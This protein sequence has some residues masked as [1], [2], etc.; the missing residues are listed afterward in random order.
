MAAVRLGRGAD[1]LHAHDGHAVN[2]VAAAAWFLELPFV[3]TR[4][5]DHPRQR[6]GLW[7]RA[8]RIIAVSDSVRRSL[9]HSGIKSGQV[10][11]IH[12][13]IDPGPLSSAP[14]SAVRRQLGLPVGPLAVTVA[15]LDRS[16]GHDAIIRTNP[17]LHWAFAGQGPARADLEALARNLGVTSI[18]HFV[19]Q[20]AS[21][22]SLI[23]TADLMVHA[24]TRE[25][26][27][28]TI[29]DAMAVGVPVVA[30]R[31]GGIVELLGDGGG[32][33]V[34]PGAEIEIAAA[35]RR[36][37]SDEKWRREITHKA[38]DTV[39]RFSAEGMAAKVLEVYRSV[40]LD[41]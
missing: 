11:V 3:A 30:T 5:L 12:S 33:L 21:P 10:T 18:I 31:V 39:T 15:A 24:P 40:A 23:A 35:V 13:G 36:V 22:T 7:K 8:A 4:R 17:G 29:L 6:P 1:I 14:T 9:E 32:V 38:M 25:A 16:K 2:L 19:G 28:T 26:L 27:G 34:E 37:L 41:R 20:L